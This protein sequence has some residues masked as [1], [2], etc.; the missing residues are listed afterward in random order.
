MQSQHAESQSGRSDAGQ[1][2]ELMRESN[3]RYSNMLQLLA[4]VHIPN[5]ENHQLADPLAV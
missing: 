2:L 1:W 4:G 5:R 3:E